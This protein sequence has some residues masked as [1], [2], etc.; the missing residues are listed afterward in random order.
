MGH[1]N[2]GFGDVG[3]DNR[4][5][6]GGRDRKERRDTH[7]GGAEI[8]RQRLGGGSVVGV[9]GVDDAL[10]CQLDVGRAVAETRVVAEVAAFRAS[11]VGDTFVRAS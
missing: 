1:V 7:D 11:W 8:T 6:K 9:A 5:G 3:E 4:M 2:V 10:G